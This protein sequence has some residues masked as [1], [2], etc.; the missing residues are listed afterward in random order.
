MLNLLELS[1]ALL[2]KRLCSL[3][4]VGD[5]D[6]DDEIIY[7]C[8]CA[9]TASCCRPKA[10]IIIIIIITWSSFQIQSI[11][12]WPRE[13]IQTGRRRRRSWQASSLDH[14]TILAQLPWFSS[15]APSSWGCRN[16]S[17]FV[18]WRKIDRKKEEKAP[19]ACPRAKVCHFRPHRGHQRQINNSKHQIEGRRRDYLFL[20]LTS[21]ILYELKFC[22]WAG[23][24]WPNNNNNNILLP[25]LLDEAFGGQCFEPWEPF[26]RK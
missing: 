18:C 9:N 4:C 26:N 7:I 6:D 17:S 23:Y 3:L 13:F 14:G 19:S 20:S 1:G 21:A 10:I 8:V 2:K 5:V 11:P 16:G 15:L 24:Y 25:C 22:L 12:S